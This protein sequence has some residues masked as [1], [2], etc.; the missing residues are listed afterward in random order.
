MVVGPDHTRSCQ[1]SAKV[2][3]VVEAGEGVEGVHASDV[4]EEVV[5]TG[6]A[7]R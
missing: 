5:A 2:S 7:V 1:L 6:G 3:I 4:S